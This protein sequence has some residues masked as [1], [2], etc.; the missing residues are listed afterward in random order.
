[1]RRYTAVLLVLILTGVAVAQQHSAPKAAA[2]AEVALPSEAT[3]NSF[4]QHMFAYD[5]EIS[6]RI[7]RIGPAPAPG[8]G[9]VVVAMKGPQG[10]ENTRLFITPDGQHAIWPAGD[11]IPFGADPFAPARA[12]LAAGAHGPSRG[13]ANANISIV[14]FSDLQCPSCKAAQP[15]IDKLLED[16]P[17]ARFTFQNFP[18][19][20]I[21][22]W[23][24]KAAS[25]ADCVGRQNN[26]AFWKFIHT[27]YASQEQIT[28]A[29][30]DEKL[31]GAAAEAG[32]NAPT[33]AACAA[34][35]ATAERVR[36]S[37]ALGEALDI[38]STPTLFING[39]KVANVTGLPPELL[40]GIAERT[41]R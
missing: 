30:A 5:P 9:E 22:K 26:D 14:E 29:N 23:A 20:R 10:Q 17:N 6:W 18:L 4:L 12:E 31:R 34:E 1:M 28:E 25:Y 33:V 13:P 16:L 21:H 15:S 3:V 24:F 19:E 27:V 35:P 37:M 36:Q 38:N 41:P 11:I 40:K 2:K 8:I 7:L 39:R 32:L